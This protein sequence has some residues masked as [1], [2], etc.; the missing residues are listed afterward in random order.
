M[1]EIP[2]QLRSLGGQSQDLCHAEIPWQKFR[3]YTLHVLG[4]DS[5]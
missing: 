3:G 2:W 4:F 1:A 5:S